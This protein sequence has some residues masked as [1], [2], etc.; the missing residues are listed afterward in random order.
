MVILM[1][2]IMIQIMVEIV[3]IVI[4]NRNNDDSNWGT[5]RSLGGYE[6]GLGNAS[7]RDGGLRSLLQ[8]ECL[9]F[10]VGAL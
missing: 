1:Q 7:S 3:I 6:R 9:F 8:F 2:E 5:S 4:D 10:G